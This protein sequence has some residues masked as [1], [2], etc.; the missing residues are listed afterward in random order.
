MRTAFEYILSRT[1][2]KPS[3]DKLIY[4]KFSVKLLKKLSVTNL[5]TPAANMWYS[6]LNCIMFVKDIPLRTTLIYS[7]LLLMK[8]F[9]NFQLNHI[10]NFNFCKCS[11]LSVL[12]WVAGRQKKRTFYYITLS[13]V[14]PS[15]RKTF[16]REYKY[17][18]KVPCWFI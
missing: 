13:H 4:F 10:I 11:M 6:T 7:T 15:P 18:L 3:I 14:P 16:S 5:S 9:S 17:Q 8:L 2:G 12:S 1:V